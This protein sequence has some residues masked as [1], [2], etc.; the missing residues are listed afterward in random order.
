MIAAEYGFGCWPW[1][2][3]QSLTSKLKS[4]SCLWLVFQ[5][6]QSGQA[7]APSSKSSRRSA[8]A[9]DSADAAVR[10][11]GPTFQGPTRARV[12]CCSS[13]GTTAPSVRQL[14]RAMRGGHS[15]QDRG[16]PRRYRA[17][18]PRSRGSGRGTVRSG[19]PR[20]VV[21]GH[22]YESGRRRLHCA[23][24]RAVRSEARRQP[25]RRS[26]FRLRCTRALADDEQWRDNRDPISGRPARRRET[27]LRASPARCSEGRG[28]ARGVA[29]TS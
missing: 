6:T 10:Q 25:F 16:A 23:G 17:H 29:T 13:L 15:G 14:H 20:W 21:A 5:E 8:R 9:A 4:G 12:D 24:A 11:H 26:V 3:V 7:C 19:S 2:K 1:Q 27:H 22:S 18:A 28:Q